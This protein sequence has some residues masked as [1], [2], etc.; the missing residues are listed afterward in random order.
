MPVGAIE[1]NRFAVREHKFKGG[2]P[3]GF[4]VA[5][6]G[7]GKAV[8][9]PAL[10]DLF[11]DFLGACALCLQCQGLDENI[12]NG[13]HRVTVTQMAW[14]VAFLVL[15]LILRALPGWLWLTA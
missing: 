12:A 10:D 1:R 6:F 15:F 11:F 3:T 7:Y 2:R 8:I 14:L 5:P 9:L 13:R 4:L